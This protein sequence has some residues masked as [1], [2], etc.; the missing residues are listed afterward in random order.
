MNDDE[1]VKA[2]EKVNR[3]ILGTLTP[4]R[5][6][7]SIRVAVL[8]R[9]LCTRFGFDPLTGYL[10]GIAHDMCKSAQDQTLLTLAGGDSLP[11]STIER[12][13]PSLLHGRAAAV[14]LGTEY[15]VTDASILEAVRH[16][17]FGKPNLDSLGKIVF[18]AD[19]IEPGRTGVNSDLRKKILGSDLG[20]MTVLVLEKHISYLE[21]R[22]KI[23]AESTYSMME[24][25]KRRKNKP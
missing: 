13:K 11:I 7:H 20:E 25:L 23:V 3:Y 4:P 10:A 18:V 15:G 8:A 24:N 19:K 5:Y 14:L 2:S 21:E 1:I 6:A 9:N 22:G 12:D 16:H 17:T